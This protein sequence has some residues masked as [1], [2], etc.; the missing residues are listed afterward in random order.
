MQQNTG[1]QSPETRMDALCGGIEMQLKTNTE[2]L[3]RLDKIVARLEEQPPAVDG[4]QALAPKPIQQFGPGHLY[5]LNDIGEALARQN[6]CFD[7]LLN[8]LESRI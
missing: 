6:D 2:W 4:G 3:T 1:T 7:R 8:R 5:R